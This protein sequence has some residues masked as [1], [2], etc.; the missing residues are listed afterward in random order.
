MAGW[1]GEANWSRDVLER[2]V[3]LLFALANLADLAA[4]APFL[5]RR[6]VLKILSHGEAEARAFVIEFATGA[7]APADVPEG[8][9]DATCVAVRLRA[10][11]LFLYALLARRSALS[12]AAGP[13][14]CRRKPAGPASRHAQPPVPDTS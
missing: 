11:A 7:A 3:I 6:Q 4:D 9:G 13:R 12:G 5:R 10:L 2:I 8:A 14:A 1:D